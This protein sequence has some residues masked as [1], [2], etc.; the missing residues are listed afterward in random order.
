MA[1]TIRIKRSGT[2]GDPTTLG[3][4]ELAYS[5]LPD[6]GSNGGDRLYIGTG[7]EIAGNAVNHEVIG[8]KFFTQMLDHAKGTLTPNSAII[9]DADSKIDILKVDDI[10]IDGSSISVVGGLTF[11]TQG[12]EIDFGNVSLHGVATPVHD[13]DAANKAYVDSLA[14]EFIATV[15]ADNGSFNFIPS[16]EYVTYSGGNAITTSVDSGSNSIIFDLDVTG[17]TAGSYGSQTAIPTFTVDSDG[18]LTSASTVDV[19]T[20]LTVNNDAI[21]LLDSDLTF[22]ATGNGLTL[23]YTA[24][25]NTV[26]YSIDDAT[27]SS[28][29]VAQF[30][31][32]DFGVSSGEVSLNDAVLKTFATDSGTATG[33]G[34]GLTITGNSVQG[35]FTEATGSTITVD[36]QNA[37]YS[38]RGVAKFQSADFVLNDGDVSLDS[39]VVKQIT[40]DDGNVPITGHMV[41]ILG[42]EGINVNHA[43]TNISVSGED[44]TTSNKG[45]ASFNSADFNVSNGEVSIASIGNSQIDNA[46]VTIGDTQ[47]D[48]GAT[49]TDLTGLTGATVDNIRID[50]NKISTNTA[51]D[52]L[53]LDPKSG[54]SN[55]GQVLVLGDLVVQGT[56]TIINSTTMSVNDLNLVLADSAADATAANGAGITVN[57]ADA[58][59]TYSVAGDK[60]NTNKD[61]DV[62]GDIYY[63]GTILR[64]Y[65][66]DH[67]GNNF[68]AAGEGLDLTYGSAQDSD[69]TIIFSAELA[70]Y[71]NK[72]VASFDSDQFTLSSGFVTVSELDGGTY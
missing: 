40:T 6:N 15:A 52:V 58:T 30:L 12:N 45:I 24:S 69:N 19:A 23:T 55:G 16:S 36:V 64:E 17:V 44:A 3:Q 65:I 2:S 41:S 47:V 48:L 61:L 42:G 72:G 29:G 22:T 49:I 50:G 25:T 32:D 1:S 14:A 11:D 59:I 67:L 7:T 56:Q 34:H 60:W 53:V 18:R 33:S 10:T 4:G 31:S 26:D 43:G 70:T 68:F 38:Q 51:T 62:G 46:N 66:E 27:T 37:S 54:D 57:G 5:Y 8:G 21:S 9:V 35:I 39:A 63:N 71:E 20:N 13:S 28:K